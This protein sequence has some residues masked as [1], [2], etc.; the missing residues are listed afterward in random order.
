[1]HARQLVELSGIL[2]AQGP[3]LVA[4]TQPLSPSGL[5]QY[6]T[7]SKCR[8][9][10]WSRSLRSLTTEAQ[11][12]DGA[13]PRPGWPHLRGVLEEIF[14]GEMLTRV[15][16]ALVCLCGQ[17]HD[18]SDAEAVTRSVLVGQ[19]EAR[20]RALTLLV[21]G[22]G[23]QVA[24]AV[25]INHLLRRVERWTDL[26]LGHLGGLGDVSPLANDAQRVRD[27]A[28]DLG[29]RGA[30]ATPQAVRLMLGSLRLAFRQGL[31]PES[32]NEDLN[33]AIASAILAC[34]PVEVFDG[35]G[36]FQSPWLLR[37]Y[38]LTSD[39]EGMIENLLG[40]TPTALGPS[41]GQVRRFGRA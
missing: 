4:G 35:T 22:P 33:E 7:A 19:Q 26:L 8:L 24:E 31:S 1:M 14:T 13:A 9:D 11:W 36:Q 32:P 39:V 15:W 20:H 5:A 17:R 25:R 27:F 10:R 30:A 2:A 16:T 40:P 6:W 41:P 18:C 29:A 12:Q 23:I 37:I 28:D 3:L 38:N 34:L 21:D